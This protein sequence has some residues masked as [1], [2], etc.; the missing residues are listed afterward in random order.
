MKSKLLAALTL[1]TASSSF[2]YVDKDYTGLSD[3]YEFI[4]FN[5]P[6]DPFADADGDGVS[7]YDEMIWGTNPTNAASKVT[8]PTATLTGQVLRFAWPAAPYRLYELRA[9]EDML[10]WRTILSGTNTIYT[11]NLSAAN[12]PARRFY[13][14]SVSFQ[15]TGP[16]P[17]DLLATPAGPD[18]VLTWSAALNQIYDLQGSANL[19][20]WQTLAANARTKTIS[21]N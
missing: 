6:A 16:L 10:T 4:Y 14:L 9:S 3:V 18:L 8:G 20:N 13:R 5:G 19:A 2:A 21:G 17:A 7:N 15:P 11:E 12:A 1:L